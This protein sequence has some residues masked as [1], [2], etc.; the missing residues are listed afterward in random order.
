MRKAIV[1]KHLT[2]MDAQAVW[3]ELESHL[4]KSSKARQN[5]ANYI[6]MS[7]PP[8]PCIDPGKVVLN[9]LFSTSMKSSENWMKYPLPMKF[10]HFPPS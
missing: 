5:N 3:V 2:T 6:H 8:P 10:F 9:I 1:R 4:T 7:P